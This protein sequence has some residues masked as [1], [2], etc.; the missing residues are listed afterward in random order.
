LDQTLSPSV[1]SLTPTIEQVNARDS[2]ASLINQLVGFSHLFGLSIAEIWLPGLVAAREPLAHVL[3][4]HEC[5]KRSG[6]EI[7]GG[8]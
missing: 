5:L 4:L 7:V 6:H 1:L 8:V 3:E 2:R